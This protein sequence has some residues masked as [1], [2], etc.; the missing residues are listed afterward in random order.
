MQY[1]YDA[2]FI[3]YLLVAGGD[4]GGDGLFILA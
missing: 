2:L 3:I 4:N 1:T